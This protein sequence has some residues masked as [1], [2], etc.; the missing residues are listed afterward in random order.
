MCF[1]AVALDLSPIQLAIIIF[2]GVSFVLAFLISSAK[3]DYQGLIDSTL[4][5]DRVNRNKT[6]NISKGS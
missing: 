5:S 2:A 1:F 6:R 4:E 3:G